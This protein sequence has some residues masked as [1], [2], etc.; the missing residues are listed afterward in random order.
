MSDY[1]PLG[2]GGAESTVGAAEP[3]PRARP[4]GS[5]SRSR[6]L[7]LAVASLIAVA[8]FVGPL[9]GSAAAA[10]PLGGVDLHSYCNK[11]WD[12]WAPTFTSNGELRLKERNAGG[13]KCY[14]VTRSTW[15]V[16]RGPQF[17]VAENFD[18][19]GI[20]VSDACRLQYGAG[21]YAKY[22]NW[23]DPY[24]WKCYSTGRYAPMENAK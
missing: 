3:S 9:A 6:V 1:G 12:T 13:W 17:D 20:H 7:M 11:K 22:S 4:S 24:S 23:S 2:S 21:A 15:Y 19:H 18:E 5:P 14:V 8:T 16:D 10:P